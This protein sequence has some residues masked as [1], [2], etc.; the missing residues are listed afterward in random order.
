MLKPTVN[1]CERFKQL[2]LFPQSIPILH[3]L[4]CMWG[5]REVCS[6]SIKSF[7][8]STMSVIRLNFL[9][10]QFQS[11]TMLFTLSRWSDPLFRR[12]QI[13]LGVPSPMW[14]TFLERYFFCS[15]ILKCFAN[16]LAHLQSS[17]LKSVILLLRWTALMADDVMIRTKG[18]PGFSW[19]VWTSFFHFGK[20]VLR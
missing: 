4:A 5:I 18:E 6:N 7:R 20:M 3:L 10:L 15:S 9:S 12:L 16:S 14:H 8:V 19:L 17:V 2:C 1:K 11:S 13:L